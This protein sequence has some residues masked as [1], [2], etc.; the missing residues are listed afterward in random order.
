MLY[1]VITDQFMAGQ[2]TYLAHLQLGVETATQDP[3]GE[4]TRISEVPEL[5]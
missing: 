1:E 4:V 2:K 3:E 5:V